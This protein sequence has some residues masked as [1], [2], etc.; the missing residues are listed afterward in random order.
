MKRYN[1]ET[2]LL[3]LRSSELMIDSVR[4]E[5]CKTSPEI[6]LLPYEQSKKYAK[7]EALVAAIAVVGS[8]AIMLPTSSYFISQIATHTIEYGANVFDIGSLVVFSTAAAGAA[9]ITARC[10]SLCI[11]ST[12]KYFRY[13]R[14]QKQCIEAMKDSTIERIV[15]N[16]PKQDN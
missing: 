8:Q 5:V 16:S 2:D 12:K 4:R 6:T 10:V 11:D 1:M 14:E 9:A 3:N 7:R 15:D 13:K